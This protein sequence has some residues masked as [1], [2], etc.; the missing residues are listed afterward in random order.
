MY[1]I[2]SLIEGDEGER[3]R[4]VWRHLG[5]RF[6]QALV[7]GNSLPHLSWHVADDYRIDDLRVALEP[8]ARR[9]RPFEARTASFGIATREFTGAGLSVVR[10]AALSAFHGELWQAA[11]GLGTGVIE[12]Y[13]ADRW[14]PGIA[15]AGGEQVFD[16][17][18][19]LAR[20][21]SGGLLP[22]RFPIDNVALIEEVPGGHVTVFRLS[23]GG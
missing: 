5:E 4:N 11:D 3:I 22:E 18:P 12:R 9:W 10:T 15:M 8:L 16:A 6:G 13:G 1:G 23:F 14:M 21:A 17:L 19:E 20:I 7:E 2:V